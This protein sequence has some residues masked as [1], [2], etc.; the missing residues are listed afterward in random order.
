MTEPFSIAIITGSPTRPSR[1]LG[2]V[3]VVEQRLAREA[4]RVRTIH[5]RD[6][7][8]EA[9]LHA[10]F[11]DPAIKEALSVV[12][13]ADGVIV[14]SPV[15]KA[16]YTGV[17]KAF[18]DLFPQFGLREKVVLPLLTGGTI[19]HVL[20][21]DYALRPVLQ[22]LDPRLTVGGLF[23]LDKAI[24]LADDGVKL[25]PEVAPRLEQITQTFIDGLRAHH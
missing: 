8:A 25:D 18:L 14:A 6:L 23:V 24:T 5:V 12:E 10:K 20:A 2:L 1:T 17:L 13:G 7:P 3:Q 22:S 21:L 16:A 9:L 4:F 15:Y 11:D 19:A